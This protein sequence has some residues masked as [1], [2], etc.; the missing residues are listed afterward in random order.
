MQVPT[1]WLETAFQFSAAA[2]KG[3]KGVELSSFLTTGTLENYLFLLCLRPTLKSEGVT[4]SGI[5]AFEIKWITLAG[6]LGR[7]VSNTEEL[8]FLIGS[9]K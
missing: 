9:E 5:C 6:Q 1:E 2:R 3:I 8:Y 7:S 4:T